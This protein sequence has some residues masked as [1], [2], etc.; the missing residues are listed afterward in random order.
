MRNESSAKGDLFE[1]SGLQEQ[2]QRQRGQ[3]GGVGRQRTESEKSG[4]E[5]DDESREDKDH[6]E[7]EGIAPT[8]SVGEGLEGF[9]DAPQP[10]PEHL[11]RQSSF[12][13]HL[14]RQGVTQL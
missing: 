9:P 12:R 14:T 5:A 6:E 7:A 13:T 2:D 3:N 1:K 8:A 4:D 10:P 11:A